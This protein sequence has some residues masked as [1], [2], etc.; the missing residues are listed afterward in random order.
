[1]TE[2]INGQQQ[3]FTFANVPVS[4]D[5][6]TSGAADATDPT[7]QSYIF[8]AAANETSALPDGTT[9]NVSAS[10]LLYYLQ[11]QPDNQTETAYT[12]DA[13][14]A[15][16]TPIAPVVD[17]QGQNEDN[18]F[19]QLDSLRQQLSGE[20][21][22]LDQLN[23]PTLN[24]QGI[25]QRDPNSLAGKIASVLT[26]LQ[27][28]IGNGPTTLATFTNWIVD[29]NNQST[30]NPSQNPSANQIQ[31]NIQ[32]ALTAGSNLNATQ[33]EDFNKDLFIYQQFTQSAASMLTTLTQILTTMAQNAGR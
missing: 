4:P 1:L 11:D 29:N 13:Q 24:A 17:F 33:Q 32:D 27:N 3:T 28:T 16:G 25:A 9:S 7:L 18:V 8:S 12:V 26:D 31:Q 5:S 30:I 14:N 2:T 19:A 21:T 15:F 6:P 22:V 10:Q 23:P 20:L